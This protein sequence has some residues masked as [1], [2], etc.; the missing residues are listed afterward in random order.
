MVS[1]LASSAVDRAFESQKSAISWRNQLTFQRDDDEIRFVLDH[2]TELDFY[3]ASVL[4]WVYKYL[5]Y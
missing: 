5:L 4:K 3:S 1:M 2:H